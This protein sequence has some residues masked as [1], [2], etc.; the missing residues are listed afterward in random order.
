MKRVTVIM[1][2]L[3]LFLSGCSNENIAPK[4]I[5]FRENENGNLV[6]PSGVEYEF[7]ANEGFLYYLG[8]LEFVGPVEGEA[9]SFQ[10]FGVTIYTGMF[11]IVGDES[12]SVLIRRLPN[13][14]WFAIYRKVSLPDFDYSLDN[15][16]RLEFI[17]GCTMPGNDGAHRFCGD[18]ITDSAKIGEFLTQV[19]MQ[20]DP[21]EAGLYEMITKPDGFLENCYQYGSVYGYFEEEPNLVVQMTVWSFNDLAYSI[22]MGRNEYVL[23]AEWLEILVSG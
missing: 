14:E 23:P 21:H 7:L 18:G 20:Q 5:I 19:R 17:P 6:S 13:S 4:N 8:D 12:E 16:I 9:A 22:N 15:C 10:H 2:S 3:L 11:R 1:L